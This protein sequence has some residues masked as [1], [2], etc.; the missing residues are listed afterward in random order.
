MP[1]GMIR[2]VMLPSGRL[3]TRSRQF[4][5]SLTHSSSASKC[6]ILHIVRVCCSATNILWRERF[7]DFIFRFRDQ[8]DDGAHVGVVATKCFD[9]ANP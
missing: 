6:S 9:T 5:R 7:E 3:G 4:P 8:S 2:I 1:I